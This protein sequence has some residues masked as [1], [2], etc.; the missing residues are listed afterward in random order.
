MTQ[1]KLLLLSVVVSA[2]ILSVRCDC[3]GAP[4]LGLWGLLAGAGSAATGPMYQ[5]ALLVCT[6]VMTRPAARCLCCQHS[7]RRQAPAQVSGP[8]PSQ[9][10]TASRGRGHTEVTPAGRGCAWTGFF[11][12][13]SFLCIE[14][15]RTSEFYLFWLALPKAHYCTICVTVLWNNE[16]K[17]GV[18]ITGKRCFQISEEWILFDWQVTVVIAPHILFWHAQNKMIETQYNRTQ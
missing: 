11:F 2:G 15:I 8:D 10:L 18:E 5:C 16:C 12:Y 6:K 3:G 13:K 9:P 1:A 14:C 4:W 17:T 7:A